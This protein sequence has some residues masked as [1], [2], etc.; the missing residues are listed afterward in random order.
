MSTPL[1]I[2]QVPIFD[3]ED[4]SQSKYSEGRCQDVLL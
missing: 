1:V 3:F 4:D 2:R